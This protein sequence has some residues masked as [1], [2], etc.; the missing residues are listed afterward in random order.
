MSDARAGAND[1]RVL[2]SCAITGGMSVP[3]QSPAIPVTPQQII[4][5]A[6]D[7]HAAGAAIVHI[8]VREP[9]TG[10]PVA[11][12]ELFK[13]VLAGI[14]ERCS[15][16]VQPTTGGGVGMTIEER[17]RVVTDCRPEMAT[18]NCGSFNFGIFRVHHRP[19]MAPWEIEYLEST[20][21]Y[22]FRNTFADLYRLAELF[23]E[24]GTKP[25]YE[26]YDVGHLYN[27]RHLADQG[28]VDF[29]IHIQFVLGVLGANAASLPQLV[30]VHATAQS[31]FGAD[32]FTWSAAG[33]G[34]PAQFHLAASSLMLGGH[35]R[36]G[37][38][39]NL[40]VTGARRADS[41]A[42]LVTKAMT[43]APL[44]DREPVDADGARELL[45]LPARLGGSP[46]APTPPPAAPTPPPAA[47]TP[48]PSAPDHPLAR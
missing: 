18:F 41:N 43:L 25:E 20:R 48:P 30:H 34:Y 46:A 1:A 28:L 6:V 3:G 39:D 22:V 33:V 40:R 44:L 29:P 7:A 17:A 32:G 45:G 47:P 26:V 10:R 38:E 21:E 27:L 15:A 13:E 2:C 16:I 19:E 5:S 31:L 8:H 9:E 14:G 12:L 42:E 35:I 36:V 37:L 4:D 23:R 24:A 11:D